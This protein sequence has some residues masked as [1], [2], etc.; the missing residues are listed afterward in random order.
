MVKKVAEK[1]AAS[2]KAKAATPKAPA[3]KARTATPKAPT[4]KAPARKAR[5]ATDPALFEPL[6]AGERAHAL[7]I[8]T[9]DKRLASMAVVGRYRVIAAEPF[10]AKPGRPGAGHRLARVLAYDYAAD[11]CADGLI[12]IDAGTVVRMTLTRAQPPLSAEE[13]AAALAIAMAD[14]RVKDSLTL[15]DQARVAL[16]YWSRNPAD[17]AFRRRSAAVL[18]GHAGARPSLISV[19]DL[20]DAEVTDVISAPAW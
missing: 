7:R 14:E 20:V 5:A 3:R 13:E 2:A 1:K 10:V 16:H 8:F 6:S 15:G 18:F 17:L 4:P 11:R 9:D 19:V 12:D